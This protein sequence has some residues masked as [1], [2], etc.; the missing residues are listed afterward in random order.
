MLV[1]EPK[2]NKGQTEANN[3]RQAI[4]GIRKSPF[5]SSYSFFFLL[6]WAFLG[7]ILHK[8]MKPL[9]RKNCAFKC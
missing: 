6:F 3:T 7:F 8:K 2:I 9:N 5:D 1:N 4:S